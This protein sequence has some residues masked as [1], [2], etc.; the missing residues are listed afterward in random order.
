MYNGCDWCNDL[1][2]IEPAKYIDIY[3]EEAK[4]WLVEQDKLKHFIY[5]D[6]SNP[7]TIHMIA[8]LECSRCGHVFTRE[9]YDSYF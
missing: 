7:E 3:D 2:N 6:R 5:I 8:L 4:Q 9:D 1:R